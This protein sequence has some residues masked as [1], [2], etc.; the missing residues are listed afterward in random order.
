MTVVIVTLFIVIRSVRGTL[1]L[2]LNFTVSIHT[3]SGSSMVVT[4]GVRQRCTVSLGGG[5]GNDSFV[6]RNINTILSGPVEVALVDGGGLNGKDTSEDNHG[7]Q[8][9]LIL[10]FLICIDYNFAARC[11]FMCLPRLHNHHYAQ[12]PGHS[13]LDTGNI[14]IHYGAGWLLALASIGF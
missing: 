1:S 11:T 10:L 5:R 6:S 14:R 7:F 8:H 13:W 4:A 2:K 12:T 3:I 9:I